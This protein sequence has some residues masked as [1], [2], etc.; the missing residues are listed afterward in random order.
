MNRG[1]DGVYEVR[2]S[3]PDVSEHA[4]NHCMFELQGAPA[5]EGMPGS[6]AT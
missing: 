2:T 5:N 3:S 6:E 1:S 4:K